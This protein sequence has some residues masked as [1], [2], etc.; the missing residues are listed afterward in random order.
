MRLRSDQVKN[1]FGG[2]VGRPLYKGMGFTDFELE[3]GRPLIG[4]ANTY[5]NIVPGHYN[6]DRVGEYVKRGIYANGGTPM[7]FGTIACCD[8]LAEGHPGMHYILPSRDIIANSVE[9]MAQAHALD[10]LV[11]LASCDKIVP[12]MLMAA[13][14]LD[15]PCIIVNGGPMLGG[16]EFDGKKSDASTFIEAMGMVAAGKITKE[17]FNALEDTCCPGCGSCAFF[18]TANTMS[19]LAECLGM[20]LTGSALIPTVYAARLRVAFES[21]RRIVDMVKEGLT[22][23]KILTEKAIRNGVKMTMAFCGSTNAA[24]HLP[25]IAYEAQLNMNVLKEFEELNKTTPQIA[26][27]NP[28]AAPDMEAFYLAGGIPRVMINLGDILDLDVM[29]VTGKTLGENLK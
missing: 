5:N 25:A 16:I 8:G 14:R 2:P 22:A 4:I 20:S 21:G 7:E 17:E 28:A 11:L 9:I 15:L 29:T 10:G 13:A 3:E 23:R 24:L 19:C 1:S 6:L 26:K 18:G 12:G 27:V